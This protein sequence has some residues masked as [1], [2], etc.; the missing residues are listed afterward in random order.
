[1][2]LLPLIKFATLKKTLASFLIAFLF[3]TAQGQVRAATYQDY[4]SMPLVQMMLTMMDLMGML[5]RVPDYRGYGGWPAYSQLY[6]ATAPFAGSGL[7]P[8]GSGLAYPGGHANPWQGSVNPA[9]PASGQDD[10][11]GMGANTLTNP[12][13]PLPSATRSNF[14]M[15]GIW[16]GGGGDLIAIYGSRFLWT[17]QYHRSWSGQLQ[18]QGDFLKMRIA[19]SNVVYL[20]RIQQT[21]DGG[22]TAMDRSGKMMRFRRLY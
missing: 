13:E 21:A 20:F 11:W 1:M 16:Q 3:L 6:S 19:G 9:N 18:I 7:S 22:F 4:G 17:D 2:N 14:G 10:Y 5:N 8:Y 15:N 12:W